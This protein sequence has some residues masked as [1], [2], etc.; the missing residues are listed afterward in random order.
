MSDYNGIDDKTQTTIEMRDVIKRL[1]GKLVETESALKRANDNFAASQQ[2][3]AS[4]RSWSISD[5]QAQAIQNWFRERF[6]I[7]VWW[8]EI[9]EAIFKQA[10]VEKLAEGKNHE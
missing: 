8:V 10:G 4:A 9:Q 3:L 7:H 2:Q 1:K 6:G 5:K